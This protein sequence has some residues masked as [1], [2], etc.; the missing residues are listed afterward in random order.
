MLQNTESDA[1]TNLMSDMREL[2]NGDSSSNPETLV[3]ERSG[4]KKTQFP[5]SSSTVR[6]T[7]RNGQEVKLPNRYTPS[8]SGNFS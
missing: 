7:T 3:S 4:E 2:Q 1:D 6:A 5:P 8:A